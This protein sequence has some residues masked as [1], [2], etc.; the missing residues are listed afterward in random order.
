MLAITN[1]NVHVME[2]S[3]TRKFRGHEYLRTDTSIAHKTYH[4][5]ELAFHVLGFI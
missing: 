1:S 2:D 5:Q 4:M 3:F